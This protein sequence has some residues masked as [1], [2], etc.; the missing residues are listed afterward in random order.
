VGR[1]SNETLRRE[2]ISYC[3]RER[4]LAPQTLYAYDNGLRRMCE[5]L[6]RTHISEATTRDLRASCWL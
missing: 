6:G 3:R 1:K 5:H 4:G 2:F